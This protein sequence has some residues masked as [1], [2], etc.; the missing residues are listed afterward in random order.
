MCDYRDGGVGDGGGLLDG[1]LPDGSSDGS[2]DGSDGSVDGSADGSDGAADDGA[3]DGDTDGS[4]TDGS[5]GG[6]DDAGDGGDEDGSTDAGDGGDADLDA[7]D[8]GD[9]GCGDRG[10]EP[11]DPDGGNPHGDASCFCPPPKAWDFGHREPRGGPWGHCV[12]CDLETNVVIDGECVDKALLDGGAD[13]SRDS[14]LRDVETD[15]GDLADGALT[16]GGGITDA[17]E[18]VVPSDAQ[19]TRDGSRD[20]APTEETRSLRIQGGE[21]ED[22]MCLAES[23]GDTP[24]PPPPDEGGCVMAQRKATHGL[25]ASVAFTFALALVAA[26]RRRRRA[27]LH[28]PYVR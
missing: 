14:G 9:G 15:G 27:Q 3:T 19:H 2:T 16:D 17:S 12:A 1:S 21:G 18:D 22:E 7:A 6:D 13:A 5:D 23:P 8:G 28:A 25:G 10:A 4:D 24:P 11:S 20:F 26:R